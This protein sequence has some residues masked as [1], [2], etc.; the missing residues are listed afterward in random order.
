MTLPRPWPF[1]TSQG[2]GRLIFWV[3]P[4]KFGV[5]T[6]LLK[7]YKWCVIMILIPQAVSDLAKM[8]VS[9]PYISIAVL[10]LAHW[11]QMPWLPPFHS[12]FTLGQIARRPYSQNILIIFIYVVQYCKANWE[13]Q[14]KN[15]F[16][17]VL[18][19][20]SRLKKWNCL[21]CIKS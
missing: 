7:M 3:T 21:K 15:F 17:D 4:S 2:G 13:M 9:V 1:Q 20:K 5:K 6:H 18:F 11:R 10:D 8:S 19:Y 14:E 12:Q 16:N